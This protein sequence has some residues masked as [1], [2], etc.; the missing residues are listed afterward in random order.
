MANAPRSQKIQPRIEPI[1]GSVGAPP[2][3][4]NA[5]SSSSPARTT[6]AGVA[7]KAPI[8]GPGCRRPDSVAQRLSGH[9]RARDTNPARSRRQTP[10]GG[11]I[12][13]SWTS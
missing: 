9:I 3:P 8:I 10:I 5:K 13:L 6:T 1:K 7:T 4:G 2:V 12:E 11:T